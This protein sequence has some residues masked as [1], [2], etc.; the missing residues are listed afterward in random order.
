MGRMGGDGDY[1][2][3]IHVYDFTVLLEIKHALQNQ[4]DLFTFMGMTFKTAMGVHVKISQQ[5]AFERH[6]PLFGARDVPLQAK[7]G[8]REIN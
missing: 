5:G 8:F 1:F 7:A 4:G 3:G 6:R 2:T